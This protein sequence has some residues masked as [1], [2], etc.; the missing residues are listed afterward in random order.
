MDPYRRV[1]SR[2]LSLIEIAVS[3]VQSFLCPTTPTLFRNTTP[4]SDAGTLLRV[5]KSSMRSKYIPR[6]QNAAAVH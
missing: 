3:S 2:R 5:G 4:R 1:S 6:R